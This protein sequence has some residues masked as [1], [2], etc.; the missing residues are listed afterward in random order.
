MPYLVNEYYKGI[1]L[2]LNALY[3]V[4]EA[5]AIADRLVEHYF[6]LSPAQRV[7][8]VKIPAEGD[9][10]SFVEEAI[11]KLLQ[12]IPLQYVIGTAF[13]MDLELAVNPSVL[14][15]RPETEELVS[16]ILKQYSGRKSDS[17]LNILDIGT[18]SGCIPIA[19]KRYMPQSTIT[20]I[21]IS[22][23]ALKVATENAKR[24]NVEINFIQADILDH[25]QWTQL[26]QFDMI[27]SNPPYVT[28][29][30]K[31][32]MQRNVLD[33]EPH[34]A[35]FVPDDD[36]LIFYREII[37]LAKIKLREEGSLW[38]EINEMFGDDLKHMTKN[39]GF[40]EVNIIFDFRGKSRF[41]HAI[42]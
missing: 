23:E 22:H 4:E 37:A 11:D 12:N 14:I 40:K 9:K 6:H 2:K 35:L 16:L 21:D 33:H 25:S 15:P 1:V 42:K 19:L 5:R 26:P 30:E 27:I 10:I 36:P 32:Q 17:K 29:S 41:L 13:F 39:Q 20:A 38:F 8:S 24:N 18:G 28:N 7:L 34:T 3:P 31:K